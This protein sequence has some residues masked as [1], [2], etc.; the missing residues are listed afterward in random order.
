MSYEK[1]DFVS[2][3]DPLGA[4]VLVN[5]PQIKFVVQ[6]DDICRLFFGGGEDDFLTVKGSIK[7]FLEIL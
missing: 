4:E 6:D 3:T 7:D 5:I 2:M 1:A